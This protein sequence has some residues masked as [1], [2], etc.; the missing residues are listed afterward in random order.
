MKC[1]NCNNEATSWDG[2]WC[3]DCLG[4]EAMEDD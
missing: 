3:R 4:D 2:L 1:I